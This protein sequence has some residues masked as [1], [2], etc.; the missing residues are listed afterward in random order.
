[1]EK[2]KAKSLA[3]A[4]SFEHSFFMGHKVFIIHQKL[5]K[6]VLNKYL[7]TIYKMLWSTFLA[8]TGIQEC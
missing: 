3:H 6:F 8:S 7:G 1:M 4:S 5:L 2:K